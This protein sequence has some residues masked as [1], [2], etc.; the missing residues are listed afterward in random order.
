MSLL[1]PW[2]STCILKCFLPPHGEAGV[3]GRGSNQRQ[4][5]DFGS[6]L[7][8]TAVNGITGTTGTFKK[9]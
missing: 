5:V 3:K 4:C 9:G 1:L 6:G 2:I 8:K 7:G